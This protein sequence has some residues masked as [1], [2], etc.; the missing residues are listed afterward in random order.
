MRG[1]SRI[2][3]RDADSKA[4]FVGSLRVAIEA[5]KKIG[6]ALRWAATIGW[7][8]ETITAIREAHAILITEL[9]KLAIAL[10]EHKICYQAEA[11]GL[12]TV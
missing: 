7:R 1:Y 5:L 8:G 12:Y 3:F 2:F 9:D 11:E 6:Q 10:G 4:S